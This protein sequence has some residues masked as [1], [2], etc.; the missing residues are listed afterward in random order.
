LRLLLISCFPPLSSSRHLQCRGI[1][2]G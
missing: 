1:G 2:D